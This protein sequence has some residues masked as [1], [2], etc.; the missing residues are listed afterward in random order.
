MQFV[1]FCSWG[2]HNRVIFKIVRPAEGPG[3]VEESESEDNLPPG[4]IIYPPVMDPPYRT[5]GY[6]VMSR[7]LVLPQ[8]ILDAINSEDS[9]DS[10]QPDQ[11]EE[12]DVDQVRADFE[13]SGGRAGLI[14]ASQAAHA[15]WMRML[16]APPA[17]KYL[18]FKGSAA[19]IKFLD[20]EVPVLKD[21]DAACGICM[22]TYN[23]FTEFMKDEAASAK[24]PIWTSRHSVYMPTKGLGVKEFLA[25][26]RREPKDRTIRGK[27]IK[28]LV[29]T[30]CG[31]V[32]CRQC[33]KDWV[34]SAGSPSTC[35][36][37]RAKVVDSGEPP[38]ADSQGTPVV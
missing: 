14:A 30:T 6:D 16:Q 8:D 37:C 38:A 4:E 23:D 28:L 17:P 9:F 21:S 35:P 18:R 27:L 19:V 36:L 26:K 3:F 31:H 29:Q 11:F 22:Q 15:E 12:I 7:C 1:R 33:L 24:E 25:L 5:G 20:D 2:M 10:E 32:F 13:A 34:K